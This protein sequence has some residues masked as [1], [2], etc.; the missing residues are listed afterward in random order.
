MSSDIAV[1][2]SYI[3]A[4]HRDWTPH[5][6]Q[7]NVGRA[8]FDRG[9][10]RIFIQC[11]RKWGKSEILMYILTRWALIHANSSCYY[12]APFMKQ[13]KEIL[14]H[15]LL[16]FI[17]QELVS[18]VNK[19][20]MRITL[21]NG[22]FIKLDGSDN[23][24]AYRGITPDVVVYDEF[25]DFR[26]E[27]HIGMEP[28][29]APRN[30]PLIIAGT[31]PDVDGQYV[32]LAEEF[33]NDPAAFHV[34]APTHENPHIPKEWLE[35]TKNRLFSRNEIDVWKREYLGQFVKGGSSAIFPMFDDAIHVKDHDEVM[36][37]ISR[38]KKKFE[39]FTVT[40]PGT[41]SVFGGLIG[42]M[43]PYTRH[44]YIL[45]E[46]YITDQRETSTRRVW[47]RLEAIERELHEQ[48]REDDFDRRY[49]EAA[50]W[51]AN[52][53]LDTFGVSFAPTSKAQNKKE[54]GLSLIKDQL[55][56]NKVTLSDRCVKLI[57][58]LENYIRDRNG[59]I[60]KANDH[61]ID[62]W[63]YLNAAANY[64]FVETAEP[65]PA[66]KEGGRR[67]FSIEEEV[68]EFNDDPFIK[69]K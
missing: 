24:E 33:R 23:Y 20:E 57:W 12:I 51:F 3:A 39:W 5:A 29:L 14:W 64:E 68:A 7:V 28:N 69:Y 11:G 18:E 19:T 35:A 36:E 16:R 42:C 53:V 31:P 55:I 50:A 47:P 6:G 41:A 32:S 62:C 27:F 48:A 49:D 66:P 63:R 37:S 65:V 21:I 15:R 38:D 56:F 60:P 30:A 40:D 45:D 52:E 17:P 54:Q 61:L 58:E 22:S 9:I 8:L 26:P 59:K 67:G 44:V 43:N 10:R 25:K 13:A 2:A 1:Y 4:L 46:I 34:I